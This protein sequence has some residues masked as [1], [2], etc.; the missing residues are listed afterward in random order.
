[1]PLPTSAVIVGVLSSL[2]QTGAALAYA[3]ALVP[4]K[5]HTTGAIL[6]TQEFPAVA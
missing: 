1:M 3:P 2:F 5:N 6:A 4:Q